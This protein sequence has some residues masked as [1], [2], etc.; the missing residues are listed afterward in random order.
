MKPYPLGPWSKGIVNVVPPHAVPAD[1]LVSA[2]NVDIDQAGNVIRRKSWEQADNAPAH[3]LFKHEGVTYGVVDGMLGVLDTDGFTPKRAVAG[4]LNWTVLNGEPVWTDGQEVAQVKGLLPAD[5]NQD[6]EEDLVPLPGG[7]WVEY[8]QGR[9]VVARGRTLYFSRPLNYGA[10]D[11]MRDFLMMGERVIWMVALPGGMYVGLRNSVQYLGGAGYPEITQKIVAGPSWPGAAT[12]I[13]SERL[14]E[15]V[16]EG[17]QH[18]VYAV[19]MTSKGFALGSPT[20]VV[21]YPQQDR[22]DGIPVHSGSLV[23]LGDRIT[24]LPN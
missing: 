22:L 7:Q 8:W 3:S 5:F 16:T 13:G 15:K 14:G 21:V 19:W 4:R 1:A 2:V 20:G 17:F 9:L 24:V 10:C 23:V 11:P 12:V 6:H 18:E